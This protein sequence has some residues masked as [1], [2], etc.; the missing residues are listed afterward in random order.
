MKIFILRARKGPT[1]PDYIEPNIGNPHHFEIIAHSIVSALFISRHMRPDVLFYVVLEG[2]PDPPKTIVFDSQKLFYLGGFDER[3]IISV[4]KRALKASNNLVKDETRDIDSGLQVT[5]T[6][7]EH[8]VKDLSQRYPI[9][10]LSKKGS[11]IREAELPENCCFIFTDHIPM[12]KK[13][14]YL[15]KRLGVKKL[16][17]GPTMLFAAHCI[18]LVHNELDRREKIYGPPGTS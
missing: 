7:F 17:V 11:D 5:R 9:Y 14:F 16:K 4:V 10:I 1:A 6:S 8:L 18:V 2:S 13:T 12:Q 15:L 3:T